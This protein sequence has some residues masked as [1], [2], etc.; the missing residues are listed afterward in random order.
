MLRD[1]HGLRVL[2]VDDEPLVLRMVA[3]M[4]EHAGFTVEAAHDGSGALAA[5][6]EH[7]ENIDLL[8]SDVVMPGMGGVELA[9][10]A[11]EIAPRLPFLFMSG[12]TGMDTPHGPLIAKPFKPADLVAAVESVICASRRAPHREGPGDAS[13]GTARSA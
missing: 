1:H 3:T 7:P 13:P 6:R 9:D 5:I 8:L 12:F 10:K 4:L 2:V 11:R